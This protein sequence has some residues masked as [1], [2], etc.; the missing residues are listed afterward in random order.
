MP[1]CSGSM[2]KLKLNVILQDRGKSIHQKIEYVG[3]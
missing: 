1:E 3:N 2:H